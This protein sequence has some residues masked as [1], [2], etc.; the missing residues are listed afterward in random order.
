VVQNRINDVS[1]G[2]IDI[3]PLGADIVFIHSLFYMEFSTNT[4]STQEFF[5]NFFTNIV[6][7]DKKVVP[8]KRGVW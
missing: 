8:F 1:F 7:W 5:D 4:G 2:D 6:R 3:I